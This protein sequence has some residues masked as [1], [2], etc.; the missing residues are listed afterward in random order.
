MK[1]INFLLNQDLSKN[2]DNPKT[3]QNIKEFKKLVDHCESVSC[4][5]TLF[6]KYFG[7]DK[8]PDCYGRKQCDVCKDKKTVEK[9][10]D[11]FNK[12]NM[13]SFSGKIDYDFNSSELSSELYGGGR[14]GNRENEQACAE[15]DDEFGADEREA[16]ARRHCT[17]LI[18]Q[19][20][21]RRKKKLEAV[22]ALEESQTRTFGIRVQGGVH[23][24]KIQGLTSILREK[25]LDYLLD[26]LK[27]NVKKS[28]EKP[29]HEIK[30]C[31]YEDIAADIEYQ[32]FT[33]NRVMALYKKSVTKERLAIEE[34]TKKNSLYPKVVCHVP[35]KRIARGGTSEDMQK[36]LD[37]FMMAHNIDDNNSSGSQVGATPTKNAGMYTY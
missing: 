17:N 22:R 21:Q 6:S 3:K 30:L 10:L 37:D 24:N 18:Q 11:Q 4:R 32:C 1:T 33:N 23:S 25:F 9:S 8:D 34:C 36:Q 13:N 14:S 12:L 35:K 15:N 16:K 20:F 7:D 31:D 28:I 19:E 5:H 29:A 27:E 26:R 2:P